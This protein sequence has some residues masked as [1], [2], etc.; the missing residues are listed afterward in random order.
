M[1]LKGIGVLGDG[2]GAE[3]EFSDESSVQMTTIRGANLPPANGD[4]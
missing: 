1:S 2:F 4:A 3:G